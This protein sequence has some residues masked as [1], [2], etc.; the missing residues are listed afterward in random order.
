MKCLKKVNVSGE[1][2]A[3]KPSMAPQKV[4]R[5]L[6]AFL[7]DMSLVPTSS[8]SQPPVIPAS[9]C[10]QLP[11]KVKINVFRKGKQSPNTLALPQ[12]LS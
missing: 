8:D 4:N 6:P 12:C 9:F 11:T 10:T 2:P 1:Y 3:Q 5:V 7:K